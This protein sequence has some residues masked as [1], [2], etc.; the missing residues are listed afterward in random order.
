MPERADLERRTVDL[1]QRLIR[2][3]TVNPPGNEAAVQEFLRELLEEAGFECELLADV[4]GRP[5]LIA[6]MKAESDGPVLCLLAHVDTVLADPSQWTVDPWAGE[7]RDDCVWGRGAIDM[8]SQ[9]AAEA[10]A[11]IALVEE[12]WRPQAGELLLVFTCDEEVGALHG[13]QWLCREHPDKVRADFVVNEGAGQVMLYDGRRVY[14]VCLGEKGVFRFKLTIEGR[15][16][17]ASVPRIGDNALARMGPVL[18]AL[19]DRR[20]PIQ[21]PPESL[22]LLEALGLDAADPEAALLE[23]ART[24]PQLG[25]L[26]EPL[27][28]VSFAPTIMRAGDKINVIPARAELDVDCRVP[29]EQGEEHVREAL[30][31]VLGDDDF[32]VEFSDTVVGNRSPADSA[33]MDTISAFV[34]REDPGAAVAPMVMWGFSDS[35]WWR[36]AFPASVVYGFFPQREMDF[37]EGFPLVHGADEHIP[38]EDLGLA[39]AFYSELMEKTLR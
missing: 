33:L 19:R 36:A 28:G 9:L 26:V 25:V 30:R 23:L 6:R 8:K 39:A 16:G 3:N 21:P 24:D 2:F 20:A 34:E 27:L 35:R 38:V 18:T 31:A 17:H 29:P 32:Q 15:A 12:G 5:N 37:V 14:G 10:A 1:L 4:E 7:L 11:A 13:A 22:L